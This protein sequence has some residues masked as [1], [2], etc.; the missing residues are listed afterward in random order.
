[1]IL[2]LEKKTL[3]E[4]LEKVKTA[5]KK[6]NGMEILECVKIT[7]KKGVGAEFASE[8]LRKCVVCRANA[9]VEQ[10]GEAV[11][12]CKRLLDYAKRLPNVKIKL[13]CK[14]NK[15]VL[16]GKICRATFGGY[17]PEDYPELPSEIKGGKTA[18][19]SGKDI[20]RL[21][22][23]CEFASNDITRPVLCGV[24]IDKGV[25]LATDG[26]RLVRMAVDS[27][28]SG[29]LP[30]DFVKS[31]D[32]LD[33]DADDTA[34]VTYDEASVCVSTDKVTVFGNQTEGKI[35]IEKFS[36]VIP[37]KSKNK[38]VKVNAADFRN[39]L[40]IALSVSDKQSIVSFELTDD[41]MLKIGSGTNIS[42]SETKID[43]R[44]ENISEIAGKVNRWTG[45]FLKSILRLCAID[46]LDSGLN[47]ELRYV[48]GEIEPLVIE[49][50]G[51]TM[52]LMPCR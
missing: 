42:N 19:I 18:E 16:D 26:Y 11:V 41:S 10:D 34:K 5:A 2:Y 48:P 25:A 45:L 37:E 21:L 36:S 29:I 3:V 35:Q 12:S 30:T 14:D 4:C 50:N 33:L 1:M 49:D 27:E 44:T 13:E 39:A 40:D 9:D 24:Q 52:L 7:A 43:A 46:E 20:V 51:Y 17:D 6:I 23:M 28:L 31:L 8:D 15:L 22:R 32:L 47:L 38:A